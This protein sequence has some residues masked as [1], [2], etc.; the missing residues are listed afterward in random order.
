MF[1][2]AKCNCDFFKKFDQLFNDFDHLFI[3]IPF[4]S[5]WNYEFGG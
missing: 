4:L 1:F 3:V 2:F 5:N